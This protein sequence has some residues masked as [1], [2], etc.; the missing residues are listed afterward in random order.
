LIRFRGLGAAAPSP[1]GEETIVSANVT[2]SATPPAA[3]LCDELGP[4]PEFPPRALDDLGRLIP[5]APE[6][7]RAR[8]EA[9][10]RTLRAIALLAD[11]DP[12]DTLERMM[13][14]IDE[15][16]PPGRRPFEGMY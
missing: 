2:T 7:R 12:P 14:G 13:R 6:E 10:I 5:L 15:E 1:S 4:I 11:D 3:P 8:S 9:A 16:R